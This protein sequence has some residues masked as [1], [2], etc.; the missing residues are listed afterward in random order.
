MTLEERRVVVEGA[1]EVF[2]SA[3]LAG[4]GCGNIANTAAVVK[5]KFN[6]GFTKRVTFCD[7]KVHPD[8]VVVDEW[9][10]NPNSD[11]ST[12]STLITFQD[13]PI[14]TMSY[15]GFYTK[16]VIPALKSILKESY[17][18]R[19]FH[20][21]RGAN[22]ER[23]VFIPHNIEVKLKYE[24]KHDGNFERFSGVEKMLSI[25]PFDNIENLSGYHQYSGMVLI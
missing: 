11:R 5:R 14:W 6:N 18:K 12:G 22:T 16:G 3:L 13:T 17:E 8:F 15:G 25:C 2:F 20:G 21:C 23:L 10:T 19:S 24:N 7:Q 4:Y 1:K 9:H